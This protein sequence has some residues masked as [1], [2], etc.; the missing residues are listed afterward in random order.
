MGKKLT[1][2]PPTYSNTRAS[3]NADMI[4]EVADEDGK[5]RKYFEPHPLGSVKARRSRQRHHPFF[6]KTRHKGSDWFDLLNNR[7]TTE[8]EPKAEG[9][10]KEESSASSESVK[11]S[12]G[13]DRS[14]D[15]SNSGD[16]K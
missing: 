9:D 3:H 5:V 4:Y 12:A 15:S 8:D 14:K 1:R 16:S 2:V 11:T 7:G 6:T 13:E 10:K